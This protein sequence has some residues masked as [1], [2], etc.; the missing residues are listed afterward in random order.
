MGYNLKTYLKKLIRRR[1]GTHPDPEKNYFLHRNERVVP[2]DPKVLEMLNKCL[3]NVNLHLYPDLEFFYKKL[4]KWLNLSEDQIFLTEGISGAI[5]SLIETIAQPGNNIIFPV[6]TFAL[7]PVYCQ[8]HNVKYRTVG[9]IKGYKLDKEALLQA[10]DDNTCLVFLPNPNVPIEGT[11]D[12]CEIEEIALACKNKKAFLVIDEV[13]Y[14]YGGPSAIE[15]ISKYDN[16][17]V[18]QSFSKAFGL[19]GIRLGYLLGQPQNIEYVSKIRTGYETNSVSAEIASFFIDNYQFVDQY[20]TAVKEG[21]AYLKEEFDALGLEYNGG[22]AS[23]FIYVEL[24]D[25]K[26]VEKVVAGLKEKGI[27]IRGPWPKPFSTG[28]SITAGPKEVMQK[29]IKEFKTIGGY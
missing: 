4:S 5:K 21:I 18:I 10:I 20:I 26:Q 3:R 25:E 8:M 15:L 28:F 29:F 1:V 6:P 23:N 2:Y 11:M 16:L 7:Y 24:K 22:N 17:F 27:Y 12:L 14:R 9:Y 19:A 13:Y